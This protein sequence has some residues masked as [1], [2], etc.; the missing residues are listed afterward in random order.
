MAF[1]KGVA[2]GNRVKFRYNNSNPLVHSVTRYNYYMYFKFLHN[3][4]LL[5]SVNSN[6]NP[7]LDERINMYLHRKNDFQQF[8][9]MPAL[10]GYANQF[11]NVTKISTALDSDSV[12][13]YWPDISRK[14]GQA[15]E[16]TG[17]ITEVFNTL[18][19]FFTLI[20]FVLT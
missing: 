20:T 13:F 18:T 8:G 10:R 14:V 17:L 4:F 1:K 11:P 3:K 16:F 12:L 15:L 19:A 7:T 5:R 2:N 9:T 6:S